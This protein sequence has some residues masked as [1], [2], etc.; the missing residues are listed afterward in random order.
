MSG[1]IKLHRKILNS[2]FYRG[3]TGRQRDVIIS[4]L[5]MVNHEPRE[6]IYKGV[7]YKTEPGQ[8]LTSLQKIADRCGKDC[9]R[10][11]V[12]ATIKHAENAHFLHQ[13]T[14]KA[15]TV[16][17]IEN[18]DKYQDSNTE[19]AQDTHNLDAKNT[20]VS[21]TNKNIRN[22]EVKKYSADSV[23]YALA[24]LLY[25]LIKENNPK[26]K[27]PNM[28][29]WCGYVDKMIRIDKRSVEDIEAVIRWSQQDD[30]W[31]KNI[32]S[33]DKLRKQF[34]KLYIA[35]P[36]SKKVIPFGKKGADEDGWSYM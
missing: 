7:K 2:D 1:W 32:L 21:T 29:N 27:T 12:R 13:E 17:T 16:I 10:E 31:H 15:H 24:N 22:K 28:D 11:V 6:W 4:L 30:F 25:E 36:K 8:C 20:C 18:W 23:E 26:F 5:L 35:M 14:H 19:N 33:T 3:L 9:T 34:D